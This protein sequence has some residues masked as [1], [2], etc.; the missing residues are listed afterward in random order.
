MTTFP[1]S[2][3]QQMIS[4]ASAIA[5]DTALILIINVKSQ[6][7]QMDDYAHHSMRTSF[8]NDIEINEIIEAIRDA[9]FYVQHFPDEIDFFK[10]VLSGEYDRLDIKNKF[11]Y[12]SAINGKGPARRA[13][14]PAFCA[15]FGIKT[16]NSDAYSCA[17][18]RHKFH[19]SKLLSTFGINVPKSYYYINGIGWWDDIRPE[20]G[21]PVISKSTYECSSIGVDSG[22]VGPFS[23]EMEK[24]IDFLSK[25][26]QQPITVQ[27]LISGYE[28]E[29]PVVRLKKTKILGVAALSLNGKVKLDETVL[30]YDDAW[31]DSY[32]FTAAH[33][34]PNDKIVEVGKIAERAVD[35]LNFQNISR[36]DFRMTESGDAFVTDVSSTPHITKCNAINYLFSQAGFSYSDFF[37]AMVGL[38]MERDA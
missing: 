1:T 12:T 6:S 29:V 25:A 34:I 4:N 11:I 7:R 20:I 36:I 32:I 18:N 5:K 33:G 10:W 3:I 14:M 22:A 8:L 24:K 37:L 9:G 13:L 35:I 19:C 30:L 27:N 2:E 15:H 26:L 23:H 21:T 38:G 16:L 31:E 17:I 28:L